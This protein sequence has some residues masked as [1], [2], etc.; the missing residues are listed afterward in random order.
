MG[1]DANKDIQD[2]DIRTFFNKFGMTEI[3]ITTDKWPHQHTIEEVFPSM[4]F[5][6]PGHYTTPS[7]DTSVGLKP[8]GTSTAVFGL[9]FWNIVH[10]ENICQWWLNQNNDASKWKTCAQ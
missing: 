7:V 3:I 10:L 5:L 4:A 2:P 6:P 1:L 9:I 8:L